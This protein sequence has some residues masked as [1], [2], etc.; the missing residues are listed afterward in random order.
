M[1]FQEA[2]LNALRGS[3]IRLPYWTRDNY[4][5]ADSCGALYYHDENANYDWPYFL[6]E[7]PVLATDWEIF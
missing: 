6:T 2:V 3:N 5:F 1:N 7:E 4:V